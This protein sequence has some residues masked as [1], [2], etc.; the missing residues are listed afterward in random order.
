MN[1]YQ[2]ACGF[3]ASATGEL[4]DHLLQVFTPEDD[5]GHD[6]LTH[7]EWTPNL[8]CSCGFA[9]GSPAE[10]DEHFLAAFTP[11]GATGRDGVS[12]ARR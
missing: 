9:A 7:V 2:C 4:T 5:I 8:A 12:H 6:G 1:G 11:P 3:I 10:L